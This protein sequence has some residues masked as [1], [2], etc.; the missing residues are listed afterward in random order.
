[1]GA[2]PRLKRV[3]IDRQ[4]KEIQDFIR[5]LPVT[6]KEGCLLIINGKPL[7]KVVANTD[8]PVDRKKLVAAIRARRDA[9][10]RLNQEWE[11]ADRELWQK[12][13]EVERKRKHG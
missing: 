7:I 2:K 11:A 6:H 10:R 5:N 9:S 4:S 8:I 1:M 12:F 13:E 3:N